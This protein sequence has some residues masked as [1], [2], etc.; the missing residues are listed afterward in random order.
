MAMVV[1]RTNRDALVA[2]INRYPHRDEIGQSYQELG[3]RRVRVG[4]LA[5][6]R[7]EHNTV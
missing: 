4:R 2:A 6:R 5:G 1:D 7:I 3:R